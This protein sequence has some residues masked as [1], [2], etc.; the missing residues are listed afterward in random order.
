MPSGRRMSRHRARQ[1][2]ALGPLRVAF[3]AVAVVAVMVCLAPPA[4]HAQTT[5]AHA[6][7]VEMAG[8]PEDLAALQAVLRDVLSGLNVEQR[9]A[10][11]PRIDAGAAISGPAAGS[12][13]AS[14]LLGR[15]FLD[16]SS[17]ARATVYLVDAQW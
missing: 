17:P 4:A 13:G 10:I 14:P 16:L 6:L 2:G 3:R 1:W 11:V 7:L 9:V 12:G 5:D 15:A 8:D